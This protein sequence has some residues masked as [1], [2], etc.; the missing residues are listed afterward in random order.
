VSRKKLDDGTVLA[1]RAAIFRLERDVEVP[2]G[3]GPYDNPLIKTTID[4]IVVVR[5]GDA[6][7]VVSVATQ[8]PLD[9]HNKRLG[10]QIAAGRAFAYMTKGTIKRGLDHVAIMHPSVSAE[11]MLAMLQT[12][13]NGH[14]Y[15]TA[16]LRGPAQRDKDGKIVRF[17]TLENS[18]AHIAKVSAKLKPIA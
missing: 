15:V 1:P 3:D 8:S 13:E 16:D 2:T 7:Y 5:R 17:H 9:S 10:A 6:D 11:A 14:P 12:I 4:T 18:L